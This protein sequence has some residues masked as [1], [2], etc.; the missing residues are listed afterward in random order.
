[1]I[2]FLLPEA[3]RSRVG[4]LLQPM[5]EQPTEEEASPTNV[6][7]NT[8]RPLLQPFTGNVYGSHSQD[9]A[10]SSPS[11][12]EATPSDNSRPSDSGGKSTSSSALKPV[13][14]ENVN[15]GKPVFIPQKGSSQSTWTDNGLEND[16]S[17]SNAAP[18]L[19][20]S[21]GGSSGNKGGLTSSLVPATGSRPVSGVTSGSASSGGLIDQSKGTSFSGSTSNISSGKNKDMTGLQPRS[22]ASPEFSEYKENS[23][24]K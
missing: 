21:L 17:N 20:S 2:F 23:A 18:S 24:C 10:S 19:P 8:A 1:M 9:K 4:S 14:G 11:S 3:Q 12:P 5:S 15:N 7:T 6:K 16:I 22:T 13:S